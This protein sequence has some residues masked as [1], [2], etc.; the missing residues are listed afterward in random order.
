MLG[1]DLVGNGHAMQGHGL[2]IPARPGSSLAN[3]IGN[4]SGFADTYPNLAVVVA[5]DYDGPEAKTTPTFE[6]FG[7]TS[8]VYNAFI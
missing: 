1:F 7:Y 5:D 2:H 3:G 6:N 8:N 4:A